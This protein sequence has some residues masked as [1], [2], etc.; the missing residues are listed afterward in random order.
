MSPSWRRQRDA[1]TDMRDTI[2]LPPAISTLTLHQVMEK[3]PSLE[4]SMK[5]SSPTPPASTDAVPKER[6]AT[7]AEMRAL[8]HP[9]R[10]RILRITLNKSMTNKE[11]A[12]RLGR[13]PGTILHH[14]KRARAR[15]LPRRR[16]AARRQAR[17]A[18]ESLP[19]DGQV[20]AD[21]ASS[22]MPATRRPS[23]MQ[24]A[25]RCWRW[26]TRRR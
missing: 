18:R 12:E 4:D 21:P 24:F 17:R 25:K 11:I 1:D 10:W 8:G 23:S 3:S 2:N 6:D 16:E 26:A 19:G 20:L 15:R 22:R 9:L 7:P 13:D 5:K 14:V